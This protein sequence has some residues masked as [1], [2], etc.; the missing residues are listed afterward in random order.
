MEKRD[1]IDLVDL[2]DQ[3]AG[4]ETFIYGGKTLRLKAFYADVKLSKKARL[5]HM[6]EVR[7]P[8]YPAVQAMRNGVDRL[9]REFMDRIR[10]DWEKNRRGV[11]ER[12]DR[13]FH[14]P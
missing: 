6:L 8:K 12:D 5:L 1:V 10:G 13:L 9:H 2:K 4:M 14:L 11:K 3:K 7:K